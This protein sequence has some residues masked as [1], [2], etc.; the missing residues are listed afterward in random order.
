MKFISTYLSPVKWAFLSASLLSLIHVVSALTV[1]TLTASI[2]NEGVLHGDLDAISR[3]SIAMLAAS[4]VTVIGSLSAVY[5]ASHIASRVSL[6]MRQQLVQA[7]QDFSLSDF[8]KYGTGTLLMRATRDVEKIQSVLSEG[9]NMILPMPLMIIVGLGLTFYKS[10]EMGLIILSLMVIMVMLMVMIQKRALSIVM[11]VQQQ[12]DKLTD[13]V[14]D[15]IIGMSVIRAFNRTD[16]EKAA[17]ISMFSNLSAKETKLARTYAIGLPSILII[18]NMSTVVILWLGGYQIDSGVLQIGDIM[19]IIEYATLILMNLIMAVFVLL[20]VPEAIICYRRIRELLVHSENPTDTS[21]LNIAAENSVSHEPVASSNHVPLLEFRN[22]TFRYDDAEEAALK[23][24]SFTL[25]AG[26]T[27]AIMGDIGSGKSTLAKLILGLYPIESGDI[28]FNG[29]SIFSQPI[30][31]VRS[32]IGYVPQTAY[33]FTGTIAMNLEFG[34]SQLS[35]ASLTREDLEEAAKLAG[36]HEFIS[37]FEDGYVHELAQ[38]GTNL[39]G[40]QRQRLAMARALVR[41]PRLLIFDD[42][43]SALDG[44]TEQQVRKA[45]ALEISQTEPDGRAFIS[46]EQKVSAAQKADKILVINQ[47]E[48]AG[49]GTHEELLAHCPIYQQ[50]VTSQEVAL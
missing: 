36:A 34:K 25:N 24:I 35:D 21:K 45:V 15:H 43:F 29:Q 22:V 44:I 5:L 27:L 9:I 1:P 38:G 20:D 16:D 40:G 13:L 42:S 17:E 11:A 48:S 47:G 41:K 6:N 26:E 18:F 46:I 50:I 10:F 32:Q 19:A 12:L 39:S 3:L 33:L 30:E 2:I 28:L 14:R 37:R 8:S 23:D 49:V 31:A 4:L 7:L